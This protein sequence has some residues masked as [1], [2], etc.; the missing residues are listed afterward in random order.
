MISL[1]K[2]TVSR[3]P[4]GLTILVFNPN[5]CLAV[6]AIEHTQQHG[7]RLSEHRQ[8]TRRRALGASPEE[9]TLGK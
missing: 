5:N 3:K 9:H 4:V 2:I 8:A 6:V 7:A 1:I